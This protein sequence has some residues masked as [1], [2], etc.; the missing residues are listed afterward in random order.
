MNQQLGTLRIGDTLE[1]LNDFIEISG[2]KDLGLLDVYTPL[3]MKNENHS[4]LANGIN[5]K[6]CSFLGSS[7]TLIQGEFLDQM[8][9]SDPIEYKYNYAMRIWELPKPRYF[10]CF[11]RRYG[12]RNRSEIILLFK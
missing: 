5:S 10:I 6:N 2:I 12:R 9:S 8:H 11:R 7:N 4:Y 3:E 1:I